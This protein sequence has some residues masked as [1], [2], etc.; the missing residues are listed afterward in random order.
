MSDDYGDQHP[1]T[2]RFNLRLGGVGVPNGEGGS[3][4]NGTLNLIAFG[5]FGQDVEVSPSVDGRAHSTGKINAEDIAAEMYANDDFGFQ[6]VNLMYL[7]TKQGLAGHKLPATLDVLNLDDTVGRS[8][9]I[10]E[11]MVRG[12]RHSALSKDPGEPAKIMITFNI[13]DVSPVL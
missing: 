2:N 11:V 10:G 12:W 5:E 4:K 1:M 3:I 8:F 7:A 13:F 6:L 9:A